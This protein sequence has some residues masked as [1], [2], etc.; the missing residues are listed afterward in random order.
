MPRLIVLNG[1]PAAGKS[2]LARRYVTDHP[3]ALNLDI[4]RIRDLLGGWQDVK[5][6]AGMAARAIA[7][8]ATRIHLESGYDV[9]IPQLVG[10]VAFLQQVEAVAESTGSDFHEIM[11]LDTR[12]NALTR[13]DER[14]QAAAEQAHV[15]AAEAI[16][17]DPDA[18]A[19]FYDRL[20]AV[21]PLRPRAVVI[22]TR[23]GDIDRTYADILEAIGAGRPN[24][25]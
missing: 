2:T 3:L 17:D 9:V 5:A 22:A 8:A 18:V 20:V 15:D 24:G 11:L 23:T 4:D 25:S 21:L 13:F 16:A 1:P 10:Q 7:L 19:R 6:D 14:T 12:E